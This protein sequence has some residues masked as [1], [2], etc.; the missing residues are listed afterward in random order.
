PWRT[1]S[2]YIHGGDDNDTITGG[3]GPDYLYGENGNDAIIDI[4]QAVSGTTDHLDGGPGNDTLDGR[5]GPDIITGGSGRD[6]ISG[7]TGADTIYANDG[8]ADVIACGGQTSDTIYSDALDTRY[9]C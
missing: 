3:R 7:S 2:A 6:T 9:S 4:G 1:T 5:D 8:E